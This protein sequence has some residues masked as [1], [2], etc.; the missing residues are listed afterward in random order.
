[1]SYD[2]FNKKTEL[3]KFG[4]VICLLSLLM[5]ACNHTLKITAYRTTNCTNI[6]VDK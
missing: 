4:F 2:F 3:I 5:P 1:M 6:Q